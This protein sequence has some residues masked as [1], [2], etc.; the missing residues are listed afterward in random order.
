[1]LPSCGD[2]GNY[3]SFVI[4]RIWWKKG[5][6]NEGLEKKECGCQRRCSLRA[7]NKPAD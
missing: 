7:P 3:N 2:F 6:G 5:L 1:M 4:L